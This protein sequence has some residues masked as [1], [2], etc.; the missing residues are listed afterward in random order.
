MSIGFGPIISFASF[1]GKY[2][3]EGPAFGDYE[4]DFRDKDNIAAGINGYVT[5]D[6]NFNERLSLR[7]L[8]QGSITAR[9]GIINP[10]YY[11]GL[12]FTKGNGQMMFSPG[13]TTQLFF[14]V[15]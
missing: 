15:R 10:Y 1:K 9:K 8:L 6:V 7:V 11:P 12:G 2:K 4:G 14:K 3:F 13:I 5:Y